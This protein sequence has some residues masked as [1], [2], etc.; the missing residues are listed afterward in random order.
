VKNDATYALII[1]PHPADPDFGI[2]GTATKWVR[3]GKQVVYVICTNGD[4]GTSDPDIIPEEMAKIREQEQTKAAGI[5]GINNVVFL[6]HPDLGLEE[7][8]HLKKELLKL[9]L[10]YR[11][12][13]V[14]TCDPYNPKYISN[15]DHRALGRSVLDVVWPM[16]LAP[17]SYRDLLEEGLQLHKVQ[18]MLLWETIEPNYYRDI[19]DTFNLKMKAVNCHQSQIGPHGN[20]P[21]FPDILTEMAKSA[22]KVIGCQ[23][24]EAFHRIE[25]LQRL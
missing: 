15:P 5:I 2:G 22:G 24:G 8:H 17:N 6:Q 16:C 4:K 18:E 9:I 11:P 21:D 7:T 12:T 23:W 20:A 13:I 1:A 19:S 14:A 10:T 25:V 3:E